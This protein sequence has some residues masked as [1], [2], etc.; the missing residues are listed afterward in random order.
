M[1][2][3]CHNPPEKIQF[4]T[5]PL[6]AVMF[7]LLMFFMLQLKLVAPEDNFANH[8]PLSAPHHAQRADVNLQDIK[9]GLRSDRD[10]NLTHLMLGSKD[11]G[12][13]EA[14]FERLNREILQLIG[15][16][17]NPQAKDLEIEID[18][19]FETQYRD[20]VKAISKCTGRMDGQ[21]KQLAR[22]VEKIK[23]APPRKPKV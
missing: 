1:K 8:L 12:H 17:G 18:A 19:D 16:S 11:L 23:F 4:P 2:F 3:I 14:A 21:T 13:D 7:L 9:V 22:Y 10:G 15:R 20:V 6:I 5:A